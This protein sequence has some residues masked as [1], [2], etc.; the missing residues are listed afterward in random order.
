MFLFAHLIV[1][2]DLTRCQILDLIFL[3]KYF[4]NLDIALSGAD[5]DRCL[6]R[7][8]RLVHSHFSFM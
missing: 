3:G 1:F 8:G 2:D 4:D 6:K 7:S 5:F